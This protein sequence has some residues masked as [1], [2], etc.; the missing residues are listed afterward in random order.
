MAVLK[1]HAAPGEGGKDATTPPKP[2]Q[3]GADRYGHGAPGDVL[4]GDGPRTNP[5]VV[6]PAWGALVLCDVLHRP[7]RP[8][9]TIGLTG[10]IG[11]G[12]SAVSNILRDLGACVIDADAVA[13]E[14]Y[15]PGSDGWREV[16]AA[17]GREIAGPT[18]KI[19]RRKLGALVFGGGA[20]VERLNSI[21]HPR[22]RKLVAERLDVARS[23]GET[24][25]V[26]EASLLFEAGWGDM[27]DEVWVV[28]APEETAVG[29]V[30]AARGIDAGSVRSRMRAQM[31]Y[32][33]RLSRADVAIDNSHTLDDLK[34]RVTEA[35]A[36]RPTHETRR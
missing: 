28:T 13:H 8:L 7:E 21:V 12:K 35:W 4:Q 18:G 16:V 19:D 2:V 29:R 6:D 14:V 11:S 30:A 26:V 36:S 10:G 33:D 5:V 15:R 3:H 1:P 31:S 23:D 34:A 24:V 20:D 27:F 22:A 9:R 17:F 25:A 32:E